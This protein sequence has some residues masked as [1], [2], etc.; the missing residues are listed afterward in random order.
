MQASSECHRSWDSRVLWL[1]L[2]AGG[3][4]LS[5]CLPASINGTSPRPAPLP[6]TVA[7]RLRTELMDQHPSAGALT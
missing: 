4:R 7:L 2:V 5:I 3:K 6:S 1:T